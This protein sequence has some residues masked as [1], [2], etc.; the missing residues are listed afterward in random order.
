MFYASR[1][2]LICTQAAVVLSWSSTDSNSLLAVTPD[3]CSA[4]ASALA[5]SLDRCR[6]VLSASHSLPAK[7]A[8]ITATYRTNLTTQVRV[9]FA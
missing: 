8:N 4:S 6:V 1:H 7:M 2:P 9:G 3:A 5:L